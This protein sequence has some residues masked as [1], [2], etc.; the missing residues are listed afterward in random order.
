ME[1]RGIRGQLEERTVGEVERVLGREQE[2]EQGE[3]YRGEIKFASLKEIFSL[4]RECQQLGSPYFEREGRVYLHQLL[5]G[6]EVSFAPPDRPQRDPQL[7][8][9]LAKIQNKLDNQ[10]YSRMVSN[11]GERKEE[12]G[13]L[14]ID[15]KSLNVQMIHAFNVLLSFV[16]AFVF[17]FAAGY[18]SGLEHAVSAIIGVCMCVPVLLADVYFLLKY[19]D[20]GVLSPTHRGTAD[21]KTQ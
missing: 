14:A 6:S 20:D 4:Y 1:E 10:A 2:Q 8:E 18:Y 7:V 17:G 3:D 15:M 12:E 21:K 19:Y 16:C 5:R 13:S 11:L 9:R